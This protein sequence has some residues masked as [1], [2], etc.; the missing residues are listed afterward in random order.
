MQA[1]L[2]RDLGT[3]ALAF[4]GLWLFVVGVLYYLF[5]QAGGRPRVVVRWLYAA[6]FVL[7]SL[8]LVFRSPYSDAFV[9]S[10]QI[11]PGLP[12]LG[13]GDIIAFGTLIFSYR[14]K[15]RGV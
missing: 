12:W 11:Q 7:F 8:Y 14:R 1:V 13:L 2:T 3:V 4:A 6:F 10:G 5:V 15:P 9:W